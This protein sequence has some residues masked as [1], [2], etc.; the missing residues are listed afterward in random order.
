MARR[1]R[2]S[3]VVTQPAGAAVLARKH[4]LV[5]GGSRGIGRAIVTEMAAAG[6]AVS[7]T[8]KSAR[9]CADSLCDTLRTDH[10]ARC[11]AV[12]CD[13]SDLAA[14]RVATADAVRALGPVDILVNNAGIVH[15]A[16]FVTM[17]ED[18][19]RQVMDVNLNGA[20][21]ATKCVV[22]EFMKRKSGV[23]INISSAAGIYG[24]RGQ[25]NYSA[26]K[27]GLLGLTRS[28]AK[29]LGRYAIRVN[30]IAPGFVATDM[31]ASILKE[32][33]DE[34]VRQA[35]LG[36]IGTPQEVAKVAVFLAS[37]AASYVTGQT[38][39]VNGGLSFQ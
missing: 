2:R 23:I 21:N 4:A 29:E 5:T 9:Q 12:Q 3:P 30:A 31:S 39:E 13:V 25:A 15:D 27:A 6:A 37:D 32:K 20:F 14:M 34:I 36:R 16:P 35:W 8:F 26:A 10:A 7:F 28:L 33:R 1:G 18:D 17:K 11:L 22:F 38:W 24:N 19:W